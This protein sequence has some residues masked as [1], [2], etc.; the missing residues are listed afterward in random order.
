MLYNYKYLDS[1]K[2]ILLFELNNSVSFGMFGLIQKYL[3]IYVFLRPSCNLHSKMKWNSS[4]REVQKGHFL[5]SRGIGCGVFHLPV[6]TANI[7]DDS[8]SLIKEY[9]YFGIL[10]RFKESYNWKDPNK[11]KKTRSDVRL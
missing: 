7:C 3:G 2:K 10:T 11:L 1:L 8:L 4:S 9:L 5:S 6:S